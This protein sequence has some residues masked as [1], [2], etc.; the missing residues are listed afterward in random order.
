MHVV[1]G[2]LIIVGSFALALQYMS[3]DFDGFL[4]YYALILLLGVPIGG[5]VLT[6]RFSTLWEAVVSLF[7]SATRSPSRER[8]RLAKNLLAFGREV[9]RDKA[10]QAS[11]ILEQEKDPVFRMLGRQVLQKTDPE[12]IEA[13]ALVYGRRELSGFRMGERVFSTLGD[14]A[15][16]M[17]MIGTVIGLI[18]LLANMRDFEKLGPGMAIALL[19]TFYGLILAHLVYLPISRLIADYGMR[20]AENLSI[21]VDGMLKIARRRPLHEL[22]DVVGAPLEVS[23]TIAAGNV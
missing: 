9:R 18:Q 5:V 4:N 20:R 10:V 16:A 8:D 11:A 3:Q 1:I 12:E 23:A 17:G 7:Q 22:S 19:T 13:D 6:Y 2:A 14:L 21:V 15:P